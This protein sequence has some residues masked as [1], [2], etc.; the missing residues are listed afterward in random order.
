[1]ENK[2][3]HRKIALESYYR[4]KQDP[5]RYERYKERRRRW[6]RQNREG[7]REYRRRHIVCTKDG[8]LTGAK[9]ERPDD[10]CEICGRLKKKLDYHH[11]DADIRKGVWVCGSC[12]HLAEGIDK[13]LGDI[14]LK[15][16][17]A[18]DL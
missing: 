17:A 7:I 11:W 4:M 12:H 14:Y 9:R 1:M 15:L 13:G 18:V 16:K 3:A 10:I 5:E 6:L 2:V 8:Q